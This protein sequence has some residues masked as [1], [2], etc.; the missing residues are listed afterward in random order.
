MVEDA[1]AA[2]RGGATISGGM[3]LLLRAEMPQLQGEGCHCFDGKATPETGGNG[4]ALGGGNVTDAQEPTTTGGGEKKDINFGY[5]PI[6]LM[7][8]FPPQLGHYQATIQTM[9]WNYLGFS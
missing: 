8:F 4:T 5:K 1:A 2:T 3:P 7:L 9:L 6:P